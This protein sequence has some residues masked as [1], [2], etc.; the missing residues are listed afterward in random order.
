MLP[1]GMLRRLG[2]ATLK[3]VGLRTFMKMAKS[4]PHLVYEL[5]GNVVTAGAGAGIGGYRGSKGAEKNWGQ[6]TPQQKLAYH[7]AYGKDAINMFRK[8]QTL[9]GSL[10][11]FIDGYGVASTARTGSRFIHDYRWERSWNTGVKQSIKNAWKSANPLQYKDERGK[12]FLR[13]FVAP[14]VR[15]AAIVVGA[16]SLYGEGVRR[17]YYRDKGK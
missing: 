13:E 3:R 4:D 9:S 6:L 5:A 17:V 14:M 7:K 11:G 16:T 10:S 12:G 15:D 1:T 8:K 2:K